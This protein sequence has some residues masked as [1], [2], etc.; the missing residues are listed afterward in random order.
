MPFVRKGSNVWYVSTEVSD[1]CICMRIQHLH[2][3][4]ARCRCLGVRVACVQC[5][6]PPLAMFRASVRSVV[7]YTAEYRYGYRVPL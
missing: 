1:Y 2:A 5:V 4:M 6:H 3:Y 7:Q